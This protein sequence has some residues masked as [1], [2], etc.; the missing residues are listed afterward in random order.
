MLLSACNDEMIPGPVDNL[1]YE[2]ACKAYDSPREATGNLNLARS[3]AHLESF[4]QN[5]GLNFM[6]SRGFRL[7]NGIR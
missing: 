5:I 1:E 4:A 2:I 7:V 6:A 3:L